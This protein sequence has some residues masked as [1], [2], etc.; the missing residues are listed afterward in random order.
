[1]YAK[2]HL[3]KWTLSLE[4]CLNCNTYL[5]LGGN[6]ERFWMGW[7]R[8]FTFHCNPL[9]HMNFLDFMHVWV[10]WRKPHTDLLIICYVVTRCQ[11]LYRVSVSDTPRDSQQGGMRCKCN[12]VY[13]ELLGNSFQKA[14]NWWRTSC[15]PG[16]APLLGT[17]RKLRSML[18]WPKP[19]TLMR[20]R[21]SPWLPY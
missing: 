15:V 21:A 20:V 9:C 1:M 13:N 19:L 3:T 4:Y 12:L 6:V 5:V 10:S 18:W 7:R 8:K 14:G 11:A 2:Y 16:V 17:W